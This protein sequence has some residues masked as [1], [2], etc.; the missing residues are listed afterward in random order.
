MEKVKVQWNPLI[1]LWVK[2]GK[3]FLPLNMLWMRTKA[4]LFFRAIRKILHPWVP[5]RLATGSRHLEARQL[6]NLIPVWSFRKV[7][8]SAN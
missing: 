3:L 5:S 6:L 4:I 2:L 8:R 1:P 7:H